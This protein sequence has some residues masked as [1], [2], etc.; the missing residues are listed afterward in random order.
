MVEYSKKIENYKSILAT[1][2]LDKKSRSINARKILIVSRKL[3]KFLNKQAI[4][5]KYIRKCKQWNY[6]L[7]ERADRQ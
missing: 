5:D 6:L 1:L 7:A 2:Y 4:V 3:D